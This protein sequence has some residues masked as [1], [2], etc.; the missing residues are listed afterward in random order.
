VNTIET[1]S[2]NLNISKLGA[3]YD[4]DPLFHKMSQKFDEGGAKGLLLVN[5]GVASDGCRIVLDSK[6]D[7]VADITTEI[8]VPITVDD[9]DGI[10]KNTVKVINAREDGLIEISDLRLK[11][12]ITSVLTN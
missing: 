3:A 10:M 5:L 8:S 6:E 2:A 1:N 11:P 7:S 4:I 12:R 9:D